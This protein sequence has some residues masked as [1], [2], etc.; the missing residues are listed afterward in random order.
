M[1]EA[2]EH[3]LNPRFRQQV[4]PIPEQNTP[5]N[6]LVEKKIFRITVLPL[7]L[8]THYLKTKKFIKAYTF[9]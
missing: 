8:I 2:G 6:S 7:I 3:N 4:N 1:D 9:E 5:L